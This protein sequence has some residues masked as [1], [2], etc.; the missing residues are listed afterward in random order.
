[1]S[2]KAFTK[3][4]D[5][6]YAAEKLEDTTRENYNYILKKDIIVYFGSFYLDEISLFLLKKI[7]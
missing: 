5:E 3:I 1:M 4:W 2:F 6:H 7:F